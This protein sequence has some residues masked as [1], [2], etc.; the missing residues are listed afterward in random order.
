MESFSGSIG[1]CLG[2]RVDRGGVLPRMIVQRRSLFD[3][4]VNVGNGHQNLDRPIG[5]RF[6]NGKLVQIARIVVVDGAPEQ[7]PK[8]AGR[9]IRCRPPARGFRR[10]RRA[11]GG[12]KSG[13]S[14]FA[15]IA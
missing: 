13:T 10:A 8:I 2:N 11:P 1:K 4:R 6:G 3:H 9:A 5:Q 15:T 7:V 14:P 12:G